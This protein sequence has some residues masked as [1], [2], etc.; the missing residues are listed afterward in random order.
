MS[1]HKTLSIADSAI[2]ADSN[3]IAIGSGRIY[4]EGQ[5]RFPQQQDRILLYDFMILV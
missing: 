4:V 3:T 5:N 1:S 2:V